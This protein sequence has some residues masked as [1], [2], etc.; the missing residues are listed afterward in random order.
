MDTAQRWT[1]STPVQ[2]TT[3]RFE[4]LLRLNI[5]HSP[6]MCFICPR[7]VCLVR[8]NRRF[9]YALVFG[10]GYWPL[11]RSSTSYICHYLLLHWVHPTCISR[12]IPAKNRAHKDLD[13]TYSRDRGGGKRPYR[14][15][16]FCLKEDAKS[17][18]TNHR[19][20]LRILTCAVVFCLYLLYYP[21]YN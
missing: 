5:I 1:K 13:C 3:L 2:R 4:R 7:K 18:C 16:T 21:H 19:V 6:R 14:F 11:R 10:Y 17:T 15:V 8:H 12:L 9:P 20:C